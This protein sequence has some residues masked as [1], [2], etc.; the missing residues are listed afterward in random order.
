MMFSL[1]YS[2][3][4]AAAILGLTLGLTLGLA[5]QAQANDCTCLAAHVDN[6]VELVSQEV[7]QAMAERFGPEDATFEPNFDPDQSGGRYEF[8]I[9]LGEFEHSDR[10]VTRRWIQQQHVELVQMMSREQMESQIESAGEEAMQALGIEPGDDVL[11]AFARM[12]RGPQGGPYDY[13]E[14]DG[15]GDLALQHSSPEILVVVCG[16]ALIEVS[17]GQTHEVPDNAPEIMRVS[18]QDVMVAFAE[19]LIAHCP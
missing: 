5:P 2:G 13:E 14:V 16:D 3:L 9:P 8:S 7:M 11:A 19:K 10:G 12:P 4:P 1:K 17:A 6:P 15:P 18:Q